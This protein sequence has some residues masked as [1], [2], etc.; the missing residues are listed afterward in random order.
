MMSSSCHP[1][2]SATFR[3][4]ARF[5][6]LRP[7]NLVCRVDRR[8]GTHRAG[9]SQS[10]TIPRAHGCIVSCPRTTVG[11]CG[12]SA[13]VPPARARS[14]ATAASARSIHAVTTS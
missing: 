5:N 11:T 13:S 14:A 1:S 6:C 8:T 3:S 10:H 12:T 2:S 4:A 7:G 9:S